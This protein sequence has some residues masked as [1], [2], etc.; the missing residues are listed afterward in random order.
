MKRTLAPGE[1]DQPQAKAAKL[2][3]EAL[4]NQRVYFTIPVQEPDSWPPV[5][6]ILSQLSKVKVWYQ[7]QNTYYE[8]NIK[9]HVSDLTYLIK[10]CKEGSEENIDLKP[11]DNTT[12][13]ANEDRWSI[14]PPGTFSTKVGFLFFYLLTF[15]GGL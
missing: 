7:D 9:A 5:R 13:E 14:V 8:G 11:A 4:V 12:D 2:G 10:W 6:F 1:E 3:P 15:Q